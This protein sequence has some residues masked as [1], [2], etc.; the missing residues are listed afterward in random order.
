MC[1][2]PPGHLLFALGSLLFGIALLRKGALPKLGAL[3]VAVGP[4]A[5]LALFVT[6]LGDAATLPLIPAAATG[7]GWM[8]LGHVPAP[9]ARG[10]RTHQGSRAYVQPGGPLTPREIANKERALSRDGRLA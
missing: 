2:P 6:G 5:L 1:H 3:L 4:I 10:P 7:L 8:L 9:R